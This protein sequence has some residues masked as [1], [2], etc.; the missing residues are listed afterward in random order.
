M[1]VW[2]GFM[3]QFSESVIAY[4]HDMTESETSMTLCTKPCTHKFTQLH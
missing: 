4:L 1:E 2:M 3:K